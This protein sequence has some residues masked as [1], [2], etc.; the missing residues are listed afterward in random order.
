[1]KFLLASLISL[2]CLTAHA[3]GPNPDILAHYCLSVYL[4]RDEL[5]DDLEKEVAE[6]DPG[7]QVM[8]KKQRA[9]HERAKF[10]L[11]TFIARQP[12]LHAF[13]LLDFSWREK[14][15]AKAL[16]DLNEADARIMACIKENKCE[17][18]EADSRLLRCENLSWAQ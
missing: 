16:Q 18:V 7:H 3:E 2:L 9:E 15:R 10:L 5:V 13:D 17:L 12:S 6:H 14:A 1:M 11:R 8:V 4:E